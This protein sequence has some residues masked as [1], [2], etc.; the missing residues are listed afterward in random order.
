MTSAVPYEPEDFDNNPFAESSVIDNDPMPVSQLIN[1][2]PVDELYQSTKL[3]AD[4]TKETQNNQQESSPIE[5]N[6][7]SNTDN[8]LN[9]YPNENDLKIYLPERY[10]KS[11]FRVLIKIVEIEESGNQT[12][13]N[14]TVKFNAKVQGLKSFRKEIYRDLRRSYR[15]FEAFYKYLIYNN[16]ETFVPSLPNINNLFSVMS[17]EWV[18]CV[19]N[20]LQDWVNRVCNNPILAKNRE[21][22]IFFEHADFTYVP[23]KTKPG[24]S[25]HVATGIKRKTLKQFKLPEDPC[26]KLAKYRPMIKEIYL[27]AQKMVEKYDR[28]LKTE[29]QSSYYNNEFISG[30]SSLEKLESTQEMARLWKIFNKNILTFNEMELVNTVSLLSETLSFYQLLSADCYNIKE[31]LTNRHLLMRELA[32]A[33][34]TTK[35]R[36]QTINK[37][38]VKSSIEPLKIDEAVKLLDESN[39]H[40]KALSYQLFR[41]TYEMIIESD[42]YMSYLSNRFKK[43]YKIIAQHRIRQEKK[44]LNLLLNNRIVTIKENIKQNDVVDDLQ[45]KGNESKHQRTLS[46]NEDPSKS[47]TEELSK[48]DAKS[49]ASLLCSTTF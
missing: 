26:E 43:L 15:E 2:E 14:P 32:A 37:L 28:Q 25:S 18:R 29:R 3:E 4:T 5:A 20:G 33:Q 48:V 31:S 35:K 1:P 23:S 46:G 13:Y 24:S 39:K 21:F 45:L 36:H 17:P 6:N 11:K 47:F 42:E 8:N 10:N 49:A 7:E 12:S 30:L 44:K 22:T 38:K 40:E 41:T 19:Q 16:V 27:N 9:D 34:E